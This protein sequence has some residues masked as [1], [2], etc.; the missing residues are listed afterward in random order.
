MIRNIT[1]L[2]T[3]EKNKKASLAIKPV[4]MKGGGYANFLNRLKEDANSNCLAKFIIID[5]D[6]AE[7][8]R[9]KEMFSGK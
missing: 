5:G 2:N 4:N 7:K 3:F 9:V 6:R 8:Y 1:I